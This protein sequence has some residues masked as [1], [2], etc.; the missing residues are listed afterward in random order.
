MTRAWNGFGVLVSSEMRDAVRKRWVWTYVAAFAALSGLL[1]YA[2][3]AG[4]GFSGEAGFGPTAAG[5]I[6]LHVVIVPLMALIAGGLAI[7]RERERGTMGFVLS[8]PVTPAAYL[9]ARF[10]GLAT[11][12]TVAV[13]AGFASASA[14]MAALGANASPL[15]TAQVL[16]FTWLLALSMAAVGLAVSAA[17]R[18]TPAALG[19]GVAVWLFFVLLGDLGLM[20]GSLVAH[21]GLRPLLFA[22]IANPTEAY[23]IAAVAALSGSVDVLGA[24]GRLATDTFGA[25]LMPVLAL[26]L[27]GWTLLGSFA[28]WLWMRDGDAV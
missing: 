26:S 7:A 25:M 14:V 8:L 23:K 6:D 11:A 24:G 20:A 19:I 1:A 16:G 18:S 2:G 21:M 13:V 28:A 3:L 12:L 22:T 5:M 27:V 17:S 9:A 10:I 15:D 4:S